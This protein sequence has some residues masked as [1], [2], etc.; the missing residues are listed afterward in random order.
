MKQLSNAH[1]V[2]LF[3]SRKIN[4]HNSHVDIYSKSKYRMQSFQ[5]NRLKPS[6]ILKTNISESTNAF[7]RL[8]RLQNISTTDAISV[9]II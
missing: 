3:F 2:G 8:S 5:T 4:L 1:S 6:F 7:S 9:C